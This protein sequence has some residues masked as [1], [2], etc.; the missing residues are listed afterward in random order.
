MDCKLARSHSAGI[1]WV[2]LM[3]LPLSVAMRETASCALAKDRHAKITV[4]P[5]CANRFVA[6][7]PMPE[8]APVMR[9]VLG[10]AARAIDG[11]NVLELRVRRVDRAAACASTSR[12]AHDLLSG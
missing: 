9:I 12:R 4:C 7:N 6:S 11:V 2:V 10:W 3:L 1:N 8:L 5:D